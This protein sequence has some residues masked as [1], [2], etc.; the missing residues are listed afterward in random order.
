MKFVLFRDS[1]NDWRWK[2]VADNNKII[3]TSGEG[4]QNKCD[5][6]HTIGLIQDGC[7]L[8]QIV[9]P[10]ATASEEQPQPKT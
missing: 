2:F 3:A 4:Y 6:L 8:A 5:C 9:T 7:S 1:R 10:V